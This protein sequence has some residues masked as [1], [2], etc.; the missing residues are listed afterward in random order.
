MKIRIR[1]KRM[2]EKKEV[3]WTNESIAKNFILKI[4]SSRKQNTN[5]THKHDLLLL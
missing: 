5:K 4:R 3:P 2:E 1:K